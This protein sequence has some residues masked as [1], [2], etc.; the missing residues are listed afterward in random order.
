MMG[1]IHV[2]R[3]QVRNAPAIV[4]VPAGISRIRAELTQ[5]FVEFVGRSSRRA[6]SETG[7]AGRN[8]RRGERCSGSFLIQLAGCCEIKRTAVN[9]VNGLA[10][11]DFDGSPE[12]IATLFHELVNASALRFKKSGVFRRKPRPKDVSSGLASFDELM[13]NSVSEL[14]TAFL[15]ALVDQGTGAK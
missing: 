3:R 4:L 15:E 7:E 10:F 2:Q 1:R 13:A 5:F 9:V 6:P 11:D 8:S 14:G 12:S